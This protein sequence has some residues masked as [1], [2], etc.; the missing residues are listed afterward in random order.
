MTGQVR[1]AGTVPHEQPHAA[2]SLFLFLGGV[3]HPFGHQTRL[4]SEVFLLASGLELSKPPW[5]SGGV[6]LGSQWDFLFQNS[7]STWQS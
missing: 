2:G 4:F 5:L 3:S 7:V 6:P 1:G